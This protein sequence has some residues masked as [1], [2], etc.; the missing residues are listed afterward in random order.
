MSKETTNSH[1]VSLACIFCC[2]FYFSYDKSS[3]GCSPDLCII[4]KRTY[5]IFHQ[6]YPIQISY[7]DR[8]AL[9]LKDPLHANFTP[10]E[11]KSLCHPELYI[12]LT[13][14]TFRQFHTH[15]ALA[16]TNT[17]LCQHFTFLALIA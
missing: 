16:C 8:V 14:E 11:N 1:R 13:D 7:L 15:F 2:C 9:L 10:T 4:A 5:C 17:I 6:S 3:S 12:A